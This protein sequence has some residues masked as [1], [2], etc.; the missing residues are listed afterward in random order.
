MDL[1]A[2]L[3]AYGFFGALSFVRRHF[4][5]V[6]QF[7]DVLDHLERLALEDPRQYAE[8]RNKG[9]YLRQMF[10]EAT[11]DVHD[12]IFYCRF[13]NWQQSRLFAHEFDE[14]TG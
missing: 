13:C 10:H 14:N 12:T 2:R 7:D 1:V 3:T 5:V 6:G 4:P 9:G 11:A 8:I